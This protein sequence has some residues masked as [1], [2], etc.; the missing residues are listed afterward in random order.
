MIALSGWS[1]AT[2]TRQYTA[3]IARGAFGIAV[4][5]NLMMYLPKTFTM[6]EG[7]A[8]AQVSYKT[9]TALYLM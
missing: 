2:T 9:N 4:F 8:I 5:H 3:S 1:L 6:G 7:L